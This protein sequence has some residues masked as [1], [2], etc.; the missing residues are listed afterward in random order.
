M[1]LAIPS[2]PMGSSF[3]SPRL[4]G[5]VGS[6]AGAIRVRGP[7]SESDLGETPPHP[8]PLRASFAR[9]GPARGERCVHRASFE[10][11]A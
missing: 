11:E 1:M 9:L 6:R 8:T 2:K 7:L 3:T 4:R 5:E 10:Q